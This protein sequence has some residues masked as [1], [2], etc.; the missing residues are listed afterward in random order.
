MTPNTEHAVLIHRLFEIGTIRFRRV[1]PQVRDQVAFYIDLRVVIC[2]PD[3]LRR[4]GVLMAAGG[5]PLHG[6]PHA[7]IP[8]AGLPLAVSASLAGNLPLIYPR[9]EEK[10]YGTK[11]RIERRLRARRSRGP[12]R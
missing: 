8:Y 2:Y 9:K 11:R 6:R 5:E 3:V 10:G 1:H 4:I 12:D 7:G